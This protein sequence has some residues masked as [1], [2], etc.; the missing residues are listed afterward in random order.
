[1]QSRGAH[2][3]TLTKVKGHA[4]EAQVLEGIVRSADKFGND[5][6]DDFADR[7]ADAR[8]DQTEGI[9][10]IET[11]IS[12]RIAVA[13]WLQARHN[14][15]CKFMSRVQGVI[16]AVLKA[17]REEREKRRHASKIIQGY[18]A[19]VE[20]WCSCRLPVTPTSVE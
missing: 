20:K 1:M 12:S 15:Y 13:E 18:D 4:T 19:Q 17:E 7:G 10:P 11:E 5:R 14:R 16:T 9:R 3:Q 8:Q 2:T 6:A